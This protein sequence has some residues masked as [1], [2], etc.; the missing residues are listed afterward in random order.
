MKKKL[1]LMLI[2]ILFLSACTFKF[3]AGTTNDSGFFASYDRGEKW[4]QKVELMNI[5][6][7]RSFFN[8]IRPT[9]LKVDPQDP[10][11]L[12]VGSVSN[13]LFYTFNKGN[14]WQKTLVGKGIVYDIAINPKDKCTIYAATGNKVYKTD[15]CMRHWQNI[16]IEGLPEQ[17]I[18][19]VAVDDYNDNKVYIGTSG[20]GL[21]KSYDYG[22]SWE[23]I[24]WF[25]ST[26]NKIMINP[27]NTAKVYVATSKNGIYKSDNEGIDWR[28]ISQNITYK[29]SKGKTQVYAGV[30]NYLDLEFDYSLDDALI[31]ANPYGLFY[32]ANGGETWDYIKLLTKPKAVTIRSVAIN[33]NNNKEI[34]YMTASTLYK[35]IDGGREWTTEKSPTLETAIDLL[36]DSE[37]SN[38]LFMVARKIKN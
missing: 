31:Y 13:G 23:S 14:S 22:N 18:K 30:Y 38:T 19:A 34:Y 37:N 24:K 26:I 1:L 32:S 3:N 5:G 36:V 12:Y 10:Q 21:F 16:H 35:S 33:P 4:V 2:L 15:D 9:F 28:N 11:A 27:K 8:N 20:G 6:E 7:G 17:S 29:D 25:K